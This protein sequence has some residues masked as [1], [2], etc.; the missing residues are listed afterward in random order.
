MLEWLLG[1][2]FATEDLISQPTESEDSHRLLVLVVEAFRPEVGEYE[3][4]TYPVACLRS[5]SLKLAREQLTDF[6]LWQDH[7]LEE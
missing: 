2:D 4:G 7:N 3:V 5:H 6:Q 1:K